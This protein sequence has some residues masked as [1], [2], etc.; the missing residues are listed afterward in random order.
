MAQKTLKIALAQLNPIVGDVA[1]NEQK[2]RDARAEAARLG[3]DL[4]DGR[5]KDERGLKAC[6]LFSW[7][8]T[9]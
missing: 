3:A 5:V 6:R 7:I 9:I 1:G 8:S 4:M 2:A